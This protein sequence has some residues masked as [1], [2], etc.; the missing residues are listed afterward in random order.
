MRP[1]RRVAGRPG[2]GGHATTAAAPHPQRGRPDL[3][4]AVPVS[5]V[6]TRKA[7]AV[8][9]TGER[10]ENRSSAHAAGT[11]AAG[12]E[13]AGR[14]PAV[15]DTAGGDG[16]R[17]VEDDVGR[18]AGVERQILFTSEQAGALLA[19][20]GSWLRARAAADGMAQGHDRA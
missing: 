3:D 2:P 11:D 7:S 17:A 10:A 1:A 9:R 6:Q 5:A 13:P 20:P 14:D 4:G 16:A 18:V 12:T 19:V 8:P 15:R